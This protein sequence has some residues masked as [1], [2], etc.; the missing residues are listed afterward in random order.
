MRS[1]DSGVLPRECCR[2][3]QKAGENGSFHCKGKRW[4]ETGPGSDVRQGKVYQAECRLHEETDDGPADKDHQQIAEH[5]QIV[6]D[7]EKVIG[8]V[9]AQNVAAIERRNGQEIE[10]EE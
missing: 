2:P 4:G 10:E 1:I 8:Q 3:S 7:A 6:L 9:V 5:S